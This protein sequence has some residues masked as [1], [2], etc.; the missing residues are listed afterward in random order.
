LARAAPLANQE[1]RQFSVFLDQIGAVQLG[2]DFGPDIP[3]HPH[4]PI[5]A[6]TQKIA[7]IA[8]KYLARIPSFFAII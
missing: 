3:G 2:N 8:T 5:I 7:V 4:A 1:N 6:I